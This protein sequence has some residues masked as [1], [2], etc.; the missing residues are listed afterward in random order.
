M[1]KIEY[2]VV[3]IKKQELREMYRLPS[4]GQIFEALR[5]ASSERALDYSPKLGI[6]TWFNNAGD[7]CQQNYVP[8]RLFRG[9]SQ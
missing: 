2:P 3:V 9:V 8:D 5:W 7:F 1:G 4:L 6:S